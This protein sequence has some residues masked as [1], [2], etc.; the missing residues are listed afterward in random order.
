MNSPFLILFPRVLIP[1]YYL[2]FTSFK[3]DEAITLCFASKF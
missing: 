2:M 1:I 3:T